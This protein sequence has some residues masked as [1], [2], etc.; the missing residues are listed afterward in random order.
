MFRAV[1]VSLLPRR[2][3][4]AGRRQRHLPGALPRLHHPEADDLLG[5]T[6][7]DL[8]LGDQPVDSTAQPGGGAAGQGGQFTG[9][10]RARRPLLSRRAGRR[11]GV[12]PAVQGSACSSRGRTSRMWPVCGS[13][14]GSVASETCW[15]PIMECQDATAHIADY[16]AGSLPVEELEA[17]L[18]HAAACAACRDRLPAV[19]LQRV[20]P[21][22]EIIFIIRR[23]SLDAPLAILP[24]QSCSWICRHRFT[25]D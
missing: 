8:R 25:A 14:I 22:F 19:W 24:G 5:E 12:G 3:R 9:P 4:R 16:R 15:G 18:T 17:L 2:R 23:P 6:R 13:K 1:T 11:A 21:L 20:G 7:V 10:V